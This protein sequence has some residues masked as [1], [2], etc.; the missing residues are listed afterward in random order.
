MFHV[1]LGMLVFGV[2]VQKTKKKKK[3]NEVTL[4]RKCVDWSEN[5]MFS[6]IK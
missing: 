6:C 2:Q 1:L 5:A 4:E 3:K